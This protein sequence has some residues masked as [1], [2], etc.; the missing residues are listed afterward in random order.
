MISITPAQVFSLAPH[1]R[2][3]YLSTF[4][5]ADSVLAPYGINGNAL[6]LSHFIA[7]CLHESGALTILTESLTYTHAERIMAIW[8]GRFPT[9]ESAQPF[10]R[11]PAELAEKVYGGRMGNVKPGD[12]WRYV[13]RGLLQITGRESYV[14][15]GKA[16]GIDLAGN[17]DFAFDQRYALKIAAAEWDAGRCNVRADADDLAGVTRTINGGLIGINERREWLGK[18]KAALG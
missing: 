16:L 12:G 10:V 15:Y 6:R 14:K 2:P 4:A 9:L 8:P 11:K 5:D 7:Q 3:F 17:P 13:G 1:A 18:V